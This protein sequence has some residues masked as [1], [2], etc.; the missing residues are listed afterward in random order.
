MSLHAGPCST[1]P[2]SAA[3]KSVVLLQSC[4][5]CWAVKQLCTGTERQK[6]LQ[7][8][9][10]IALLSFPGR[11]ACANIV[12]GR[13]KFSRPVASFFFFLFF[14]FLQIYI[15]SALNLLAVTVCSHSFFRNKVSPLYFDETKH[16]VKQN[17]FT[18]SAYYWARL[19]PW[20]TVNLEFRQRSMFTLFTEVSAY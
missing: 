17:S 9:F 11:H 14:S 7:T 5:A 10:L 18:G 15:C 19:P 1:M 12:T 16:R 13:L 4:G 3:S 20:I 6:C 8:I 2:Q